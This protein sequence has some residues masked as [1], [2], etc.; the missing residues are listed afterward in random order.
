MDY[1]EVYTNTIRER[2]NEG[3][4]KTIEKTADD[5]YVTG[6]YSDYYIARNN[7]HCHKINWSDLIGYFGRFRAGYSDVYRCCGV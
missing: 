6:C 2:G 3:L 7:D 5:D 1:L 4:A